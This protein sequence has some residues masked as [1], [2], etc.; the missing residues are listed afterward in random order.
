MHSN[1]IV[2]VKGA[3]DAGPKYPGVFVEATKLKKA[4]DM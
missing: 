4:G 3:R 2:L 1:Y